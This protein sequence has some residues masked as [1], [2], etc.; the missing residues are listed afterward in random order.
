MQ[1]FHIRRRG[2][3]PLGGVNGGVHVIAFNNRECIML[4]ISKSQNAQGQH[5]FTLACNNSKI[6]AS[7]KAI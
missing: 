4:Q 7:Y 2:K 3:K 1:T 5:N 6:L